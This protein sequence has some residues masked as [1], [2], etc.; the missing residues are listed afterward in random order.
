MTS[1]NHDLRELLPVSIL[2]GPM[3]RT[4]LTTLIQNNPDRI[5]ALLTDSTVAFRALEQQLTVEMLP[6]MGGGGRNLSELRDQIVALASKKSVQHLLI[7]CDS[8]THPIA[9]A[10]Q[11]VPSGPLST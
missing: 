8:Q 7:E 10:S 3:V 1:T 2:A 4:A 6:P 11:F 9:F 5:F